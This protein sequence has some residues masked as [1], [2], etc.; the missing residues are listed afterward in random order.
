MHALGARADGGAAAGRGGEG[1]GRGGGGAGRGGGGGGAAPGR[2]HLRVASSHAVGGAQRQPFDFS[3]QTLSFGQARGVGA[4]GS[5]RDEGAAN[6]TSAAAPRAARTARG[7]RRSLPQTERQREPDTNRRIAVRRS[8]AKCRR[9]GG[10]RRRV[11]HSATPGTTLPGHPVTYLH[12][13]C[14]GFLLCRSS[15]SLRSPSRA[16]VQGRMERTAPAAR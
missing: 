11:G 10:R 4:K 2:A 14:C 12:L 6:A 1:A 9:R 16:A 13:R 15:P 7:I 3:S 5:A 8:R